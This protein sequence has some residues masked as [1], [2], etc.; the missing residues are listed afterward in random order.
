MSHEKFG[1]R[2]EREARA[3]AALNHPHICTLHDVGPDYLVMEL[4]EG[5]TLARRLKRGKLSMEETL[6]YGAQIAGALWRWR[7]R[8]RWLATQRKQ[9]RRFR[10]SSSC[11]RT[12]TLMFQFSGKPGRSTRNCSER[13]IASSAESISLAVWGQK[14]NSFGCC[15]SPRGT[16]PALFEKKEGAL[17]VT[18]D[19][20]GPNLRET[21][22]GRASHSYERPLCASINGHNL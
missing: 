1:D 4:I 20:F 9:G 16:R 5:E 8:G 14:Q 15:H 17:G 18:L 19:M 10:S 12:P 13:G 6:K 7:A 21:F 22:S 2:F 11:G 3:I